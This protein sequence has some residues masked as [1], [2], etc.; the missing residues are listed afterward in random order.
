MSDDRESFGDVL[1]RLRTAASFSQEA[2]AE[3]AGLS[4]NGISDLERGARRAPRLETVRLLA[5]ALG[6]GEHDRATLLAVARPA[7]FRS[8]SSGSS[9][10]ARASL[11]TPLTGLLGRETELAALRAG[12]LGDD[13]RLL[14]LTGP[15]GVGKTRLAIAVAAGMTETFPDGVVFFDLSALTDP[16]L[17]LPTVAGTLG[18]RE[19]AGQPLIRTLSTFFAT[20]TLLLVLDNCER[21]LAA[22]Q[23]I[24]TLLGASPGLKVFATSRQP[25]RVRGEREF[26]LAPLPLPQTDHRGA[27]NEVAGN[28]AAALFRERATAVQPDFALTS[29]N[30]AAVAAI[31][32]RLDGL[33]LAIEL[34]AARVN[35]LPLAALL[36][37]L[38]PRLPLLTGGGRDLPARQR[39]MRDAIAWSYELLT[40]E[41]QALFRRL[42]VFVGGFTLDAAEAVADPDGQISVLD[43]IGALVAQSLLRRSPEAD[44]EPRYRMLETVREYGL[45]RL[46]A[47][48]EEDDVRSRHANHFLTLSDH[49]AGGL[50]MIQDLV[51]LTGVLNEQGNAR[52]ALDW[53]DA[54]GEVDALLRLSS[55]LYGLWFQRGLY[56]EGL[57]WVDHVLK[58]SSVQTSAA[59]LR[60]LVAAG[61]LAVF[62]GDYLRAETL[63]A[64]GLALAQE[65]DDPVL[66]ADAM[67]YLA[68]ICYRRGEYDRAGTLIDETLSLNQGRADRAPGVMIL[69]LSGDLAQ[70]QGSYDTAETR[71]QDVLG[72]C[73]A[74]GYSW[75][76]IDA[77]TGL[78]GVRFCTGNL[79]QAAS[80]YAESLEMATDLNFTHLVASSLLGLAGVAAATGRS[81]SGARLLGAAEGLAASLGAPLFP[82]DQPVR[83]RCLTALAMGLGEEQ[84]AAAR[85]TG[86]TMRVERAVEEAKSVCAA[87]A[88]LNPTLVGRP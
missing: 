10:S 36:A 67:G 60:A 4:R 15:G 37:R 73:R 14:T 11:P 84:L 88:R 74:G 18:V 63:I 70:V 21:V 83:D 57:Q 47:S 38:E 17:V 52:L 58:R 3:R 80:F 50:G 12:L 9:P 78:A 87:V 66:V 71:Y 19:N 69:Q 6:L 33:P 55:L 40:P 34:A 76:V 43:G 16:A 49:L 1:R 2:L 65:L 28:P 72:H 79:A 30:A 25:F 31:C 42:S 82:R 24:T 61:H 39:T 20:K 59:R 54:R 45:E 8:Q 44:H 81:E 5:D 41:E 7:T 35:V 77:Q 68:F 22:A 23:E 32:I 48:A 51:N 29:D 26:P 56:S 27:F 75:G 64:E 86:R 62:Q 13:V 46:T 85:E 53:F